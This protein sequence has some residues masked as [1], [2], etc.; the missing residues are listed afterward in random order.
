MKKIFIHNL[1]DEKLLELAHH[2]GQEIDHRWNARGDYTALH[3]KDCT[4]VFTYF[5]Y[6]LWHKKQEHLMMLILDRRHILLEERM[7]TLGT[8]NASLIHAREVFAPAIERR[9]SALILV[10]NHPSG[11]ATPSQEDLVIMKRLKKIGKLIDI[12][13]LDH[14]IIGKYQYYSDNLK[15]VIY[16]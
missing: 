8:V 13:I 15:Q 2:V 16:I 7:V 11:N 5:H 3:F 12:A 1:A 9:A 14:L 6:R 4:D 10:H